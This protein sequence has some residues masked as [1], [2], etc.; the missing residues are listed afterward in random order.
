MLEGFGGNQMSNCAYELKKLTKIVELIEK[1]FEIHDY[2]W[3][4]GY[5][6]RLSFQLKDN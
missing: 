5:K 2:F 6:N 1:D 4:S 3:Q